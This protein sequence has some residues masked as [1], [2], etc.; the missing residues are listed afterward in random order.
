[1]NDSPE[2]ISLAGRIRNNFLTGLDHL[3]AACDYDLADLD[4]HRLGG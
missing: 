2:R 1:M 4:L 3:C